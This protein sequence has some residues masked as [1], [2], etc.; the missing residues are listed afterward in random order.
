MEKDIHVVITMM[1]IIIAEVI[2]VIELFLTFAKIGLFTFGGGYAMISLIQD[3]CVEKKKWISHDEMMDITVIAESTPGPIA[4]N[5]AT[6]VGY[7]K[8]GMVGAVAATA[9][10]ILPSF[11]IIYLISL[12]LDSFLEIAWIA[13]AF[14]GIK[15]AVG[16]LIL[17]AALKMIIKMPKKP[18][19]LFVLITVFLIMMAVN[20]FSIKISSISLMI[21]A[22]LCSLV[23]FCVR[24]KIYGE[25]RSI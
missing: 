13:S 8:R 14:K 19:Q 4:I 2:V 7:K 6:Y 9:G 23:T 16:I 21:A 18:F 10:V 24:N 3:I 12:F 22:G 1:R 17:D 25:G 5:C 20:L 11:I 15:I